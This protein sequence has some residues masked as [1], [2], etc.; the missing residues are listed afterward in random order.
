MNAR[1]YYYTHINPSHKGKSYQK[2]YQKEYYEKINERKARKILNHIPRRSN[3]RL[4]EDLIAN[5]TSIH[6]GK[7]KQRIENLFVYKV[8][9]KVSNAGAKEGDKSYWGDLIAFN[10]GLSDVCYQFVTVFYDF[11]ELRV[12]KPKPFMQMQLIVRLTK[13][14]MASLEWEANGNHIQLK[15]KTIIELISKQSE[16]KAVGIATLTD[17]FILSHEISHHLLGHTG[18][19]NDG[20]KLINL[21]P[22]SCRFWEK[23]RGSIA[24][25]FQADAMAILLMLGVSQ[26]NFQ[27]KLSSKAQKAFET[28][29]GSLLTLEILKVISLNP[30]E[31]SASHPSINK[32][33][34]QVQCILKVFIE[35][36][37]FTELME[38]INNF[39]NLIK[40]TKARV[41][42][43]DSVKNVLRDRKLKKEFD[44]KNPFI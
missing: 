1:E 44:F 42:R 17:N 36:S 15:E 4:I 18:R 28:A 10:V 20:L 12:D 19:A 8:R 41:K 11:L 3:D 24:N 32:R 38:S 22:E 16:R 25:E 39:G 31:G 30:N 13:I 37:I 26:D 6:T 27:D 43:N 34:E 14:S 9:D 33:I 40:I 21:L 5:L 29:M 23:E 7:I 35:E 2:I